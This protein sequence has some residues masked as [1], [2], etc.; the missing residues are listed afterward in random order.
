M[1][2]FFLPSF[3]LKENSYVLR[4]VYDAFFPWFKIT[5]SAEALSI[6]YEWFFFVLVNFF[7]KVFV[8]FAVFTTQLKYISGQEKYGVRTKQGCVKLSDANRTLHKAFIE[9]DTWK[10][11]GINSTRLINMTNFLIPCNVLT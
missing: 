8:S 2:W 5:F 10:K 9:K 1:S 7:L 3:K 11:R 4:L 6:F